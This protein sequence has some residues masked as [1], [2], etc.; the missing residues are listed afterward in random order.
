MLNRKQAQGMVRAWA[1]QLLS[2]PDNTQWQLASALML[3]AERALLI[4]ERKKFISQLSTH[5]VKVTLSSA[6]QDWLTPPYFLDLVRQLGP[7]AMDPCA[8]PLSFVRAWWQFFGPMNHIDGLAARWQVPA[9]TVCF[10]NPPYGRMLKLWAAKM[11][12][13]GSSIIRDADAHLVALIP[14]RTG[15]SYWEKYLWPFADAVCFWTGG[16][17][18]PSRMCFYDLN[19][20]PAETGATFDAAV[21]YFGQRR[22]R[23][24]DIFDSY[25]TVQLVN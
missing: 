10:V 13:E 12:S 18:H 19:G 25:G 9:E 15:T 8:N 22:D 16:T 5:T 3:P 6:K 24:K 7:I 11:A 2:A 17:Q 23:F 14:A 21:V 4:A 1:H 20:R